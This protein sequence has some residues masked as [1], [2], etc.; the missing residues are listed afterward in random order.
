M[1]S[2]F[3]L[4]ISMFKIGNRVV[5][6]SHGVGEITTIESQKIGDTE[7]KLYVIS[8]IKDRMVLKVP[9]SRAIASGLRAIVDK[10]TLDLAYD[11]LQT[12]P[13]SGNRMWS[14]RAQEYEEK[15][16]SGNIVSLAEVV[17]DL[18]KN[19]NS[20]RS[21]SERKIYESAL[22]RLAAE[23]AILEEIN[24]DKAVD[25]LINLLIKAR[26]AA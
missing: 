15:I 17:R 1:I 24:A 2:N 13:K 12:K 10:D 4:I 26:V 3:N 11:T 25:K 18:Y 16:N 21:Y 5:Y 14:R 22:N 20:D 23:V 9:V 6:A 19:I 8:F 7:I